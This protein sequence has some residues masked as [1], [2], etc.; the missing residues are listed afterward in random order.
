MAQLAQKVDN[1]SDQ[2]YYRQ[3]AENYAKEWLVLAEDPSHKHIKQ[4][5]NYPN[6]WFLIY[7]LFADRLLETNLFPPQ[8]QKNYF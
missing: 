7:N 2:V 8:V 3:I 1:H 4:S 6:T 5:Y